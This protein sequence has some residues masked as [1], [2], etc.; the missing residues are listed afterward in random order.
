MVSSIV[1]DNPTMG[2]VVE[3]R[4]EGTMDSFLRG[5]CSD[6][7]SEI[8]LFGYDFGSD[9]KKLLGLASYSDEIFELKDIHKQ[10]DKF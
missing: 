2:A 6:L 7:S 1:T 4:S 3:Y 5:G 8:G 10:I 9:S